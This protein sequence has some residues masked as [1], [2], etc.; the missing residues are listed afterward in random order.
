MLLTASCHD[1][2][3]GLKGFKGFKGPTPNRRPRP[4]GC[5]ARSPS[6]ISTTPPILPYRRGGWEGLPNACGYPFFFLGIFFNTRAEG[7]PKLTHLWWFLV[8]LARQSV[9]A[10]SALA[11][12]QLF[13]FSISKQTL[14]LLRS[15]PS[16]L[17]GDVHGAVHTIST[18]PPDLL[19][20]E[21]AERNFDHPSRPPLS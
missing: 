11:Y 20:G 21:A 12:S 2:L 5:S 19:L 18:T 14:P 16:N 7:T 6:A 10:P 17:E 4:S 15:T 8:A 3:K 13:Q 9:Q 1:C